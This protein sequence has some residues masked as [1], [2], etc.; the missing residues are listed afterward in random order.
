MASPHALG[1]LA[2]G[3]RQ[4]QEP[5]LTDELGSRPLSPGEAPSFSEARPALW[6]VDGLGGGGV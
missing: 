4:H 2:H 1:T 5:R 6:A 3:R